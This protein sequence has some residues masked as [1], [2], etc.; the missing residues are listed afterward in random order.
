MLSRNR[1]A[2]LAAA[3][4]SAML[5]IGAVSE[6]TFGH[7]L[8]FHSA[9]RSFVPVDNQAREG[10]GEDYD[11]LVERLARAEAEIRDL[12]DRLPGDGVRDDQL[13]N[14]QDGTVPPP[15]DSESWI[16]PLSNLEGRFEEFKASL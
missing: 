2:P 3:F 13:A 10:G 4:V 11:A 12:R 7:S 1:L 16:G 9:Q 5:T 15:V 8:E 6:R 14:L